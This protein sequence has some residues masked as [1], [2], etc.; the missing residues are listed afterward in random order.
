MA[1]AQRAF[2]RSRSGQPTA[3][4]QAVPG[5]CVGTKTDGIAVLIFAPHEPPLFTAQAIARAHRF[6]HL[7]EAY[8]P[9]ETTTAPLEFCENSFGDKYIY[10][11]NREAFDKIGAS[12]VFDGYFGPELFNEHSLYIIVGTDS[13]LLI[14]FILSHGI[15]K[16]TRYLFIETPQIMG[17][18]EEF[19]LI[20]D[21]RQEIAC[22]TYENWRLA[23]QNF[24]ITEYLYISGVSLLQSIAAR[25]SNLDDYVE[26]TWKLDD[27]LTQLRWEVVAAIGG[28]GFIACAIQNCVDNI[29]SATI[30]RTAYEGR[31]AALLGGGPSLD[32]ALPWLK[33][34][35]SELCLLAVSR[36]ARRLLEVDLIPDFVFSVDPTDLSF[37]I[38]KE[39][40]KY[41]EDVVF[42]CAN[43]VNP[44]LL[45]Q[46]HGVSFYLG[47]LLPWDSC[48]NQ[49][50][51]PHP[52]PT[53]TNTA[54]AVATAM[55]FSRIILAGIDLCFGA[56]GYTHAKGSNERSAGPRFTLTTM[57]AKTNGG[58]Y[59]NTTADLA[60]AIA[61]M[62]AQAQEAKRCGTEVINPSPNSA[63]IANVEYRP[64]GEIDLSLSNS[65]TGITR[66]ASMRKPGIAQKLMHYQSLEAEL[67][68]AHYHVAAIKS[69]SEE[70]LSC[71]DRMYSA[72][73]LSIADRAAKRRMDRI[74]KELNGKHSRFSRLTKT[75]GIRDFIKLAKPFDLD[76]MDAK[77]ARSTGEAYYTAYRAGA[78]RLLKLLTS[79]I[80]RIDCRREED[81]E[82][83]DLKQM[84][85]QWEEDRHLRRAL[86]W[87]AQ[88]PEA[89]KHL[90]AEDREG[91][92][93]LAQ[94]Y[95]NE[96]NRTDTSHLSHV[97][98]N[99][100]LTAARHRARS[101]LKNQQLDELSK[102]A[103]ALAD[104]PAKEES[105]PYRLL[106]D[107]YM[108][109][110]NNA[111]QAA[112][113]A[114]VSI[115]D[116]RVEPLLEDTLLRV[117][118]I[119]LERGDAQNA[120]AALECLAQ[121][122]P[123]FQP[124]YAE[125]LKVTGQTLAAIDV[126]SG[127]LARFPDN[128][129]VQLRL[130]RLYHDSGIHDSARML[131]RHI[132]ENHP[133]NEAARQLLATSS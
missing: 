28:E 40:L 32:E 65:Y 54:L 47:D 119:S 33:A 30:L 37:D 120:L 83:P 93:A 91:L 3:L 6:P 112:L 67:R 50:S 45:G 81:K 44:M 18:L 124:Q 102:L 52:G 38:S 56:D 48:L 15:S 115:I 96:L 129:F 1:P 41:P 49:E 61:S 21:E 123:I 27:E 14:R 79:A 60:N 105:H 118:Y 80:N 131:L 132:L 110:L 73:G 43:H 114:Y 66:T 87:Q 42:I 5:K 82:S 86:L 24:K 68:K 57:R 10:N 133:N 126:Y 36:I 116:L 71:N 76:E 77:D 92:D 16:G 127:F 69:L 109:E 63:K 117:A 103:V 106:V 22:V 128:L 39:M 75:L 7:A 46:W 62:G 111:S 12:A 26:L 84:F 130:A 107:G 104:H 2:A 34:H 122:S 121:L 19:G 4:T 90:T 53:V 20:L 31:T 8:R 113:D 101:L 58:W 99:S 9:V 98:R 11:V 25:E 108:A 89:A 59:A 94:R 70:A 64:L 35:R 72:D 17:K 85:K 78:E 51:L 88:H 55:G 95:E 125:L 100:T 23:A 29:V 74:E 13:G 97:Q